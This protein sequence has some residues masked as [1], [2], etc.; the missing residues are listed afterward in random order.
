[1]ELSACRAHAHVS[2]L[3]HSLAM[4]DRAIDMLTLR[5]GVST[6]NNILVPA[7][8]ARGTSPT[9]NKMEPT[10]RNIDSAAIMRS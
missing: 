6:P 8:E 3:K 9:A 4:I 10:R 2:K 5:Q 1:L 7:P